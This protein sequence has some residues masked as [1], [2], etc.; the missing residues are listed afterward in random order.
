[1]IPKIIHIIQI[2]PKNNHYNVLIRGQS[3]LISQIIQNNTLVI[4]PIIT[5]FNKTRLYNKFIIEKY[6]KYI[7]IL[8]DLPINIC[9]NRYTKNLYKLAKL[10]I[11]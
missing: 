11:K 8:I 10:N 6:G 5:A 3:F 4:T 1:M 7:E 2:G 9:I